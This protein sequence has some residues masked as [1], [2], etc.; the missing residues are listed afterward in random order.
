MKIKALGTIGVLTVGAAAFAQQ[1]A[2]P[3]LEVPYLCSGIT[4]TFHRCGN[5]GGQDACMYRVDVPGGQ[6]VEVNKP[7]DQVMAQLKSCKL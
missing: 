5:V 3:Q 6:S 2:A 7:R 4:V 1:A